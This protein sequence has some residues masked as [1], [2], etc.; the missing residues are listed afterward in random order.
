MAREWQPVSSFDPLPREPAAIAGD[1]TMGPRSVLRDWTT[2][3]GA[4]LWEGTADLVGSFPGFAH[5][6]SRAESVR[7]TLTDHFLLVDEATEYG[8]GLPI[9]WLSAAQPLIGVEPIAT[10]AGD[11]LRICYLDGNQVR[12]FTLRVRGGR[13]GG[14][15]SRR[16]NQLRSAAISLGLASTSPA[17]DLLLPPEHDLSL[18]WDEFATYESEPVVWTGR[19]AMP[20]GSGLE[21]AVCDVWLT[22]GSLIW[23]A[24]SR[25]GIYRIATDS[26]AG[27]TAAETP[28]NEPVVYW[29]VGGSYQMHVDLPMIFSRP[30]RDNRNPA[31][32]ESLIE[33][34]EGMGHRVDGPA[35]APQPWRI[36]AEIM[37]APV[38]EAPTTDIAPPDHSTPGAIG[39]GDA[40]SVD[41]SERR[42]GSR[43][44]LLEDGLLPERPPYTLPRST[45]RPWGP[46]VERGDGNGPSIE[47][48]AGAFESEP[49]H[50]ERPADTPEPVIDRLRLWPPAVPRRQ[51]QPVSEDAA[52]MLVR[53]PRVQATTTEEFLAS[54]QAARAAAQV[55]MQNTTESD[56]GPGPASLP[57]RGIVVRFRR[58][59]AV[60]AGLTGI[61]Q[62]ASGTASARSTSSFAVPTTEPVMPSVAA[63]TADDTVVE[64]ST[65]IQPL[66]ATQESAAA[67]RSSDASTIA[68]MAPARKAAGDASRDTS[69]GHSDAAFV[70]EPSY[71]ALTARTGSSE[72]ISTTR[73]SHL[74]E[75]VR[76]ASEID[77]WLSIALSVLNRAEVG[78]G[79]PVVG[80]T[81]PI[82][83]RAMSEITAAV[84]SGELSPRT[85]ETHRTAITRSADTTERLR[86]LLDLHAGGYLTPRELES[87]REAL[88]G[89]PITTD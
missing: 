75:I 82:L 28:A 47:T 20:V 11:H 3:R 5:W 24:S 13:F 64:S 40:R 53:R 42:G 41:R 74:S 34:L 4:V 52:A 86:S 36:P 60:D 49:E 79:L 21:S 25:A 80:S 62:R 45:P 12:G 73:H 39:S 78:T 77:A 89:R 65:D 66:V 32:H 16:A 7:L 81:A 15:S 48:T 85:A 22:S 54:E 10:E 9:G 68:G 67:E 31:T 58:P 69:D 18:D 50:R 27:I 76:A 30:G 51:S 63:V 35:S 33:L 55:D 56:Q 57:E 43:R 59:P 14:R 37:G 17:N 83:S 61:V 1:G 70:A 26:L 72:S 19:A 29:T 6:G 71:P 87:R 2:T 23:G 8:F 44:H 88:L 84:V 38:P 46:R